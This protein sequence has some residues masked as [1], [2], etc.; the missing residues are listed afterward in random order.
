MAFSY[1]IKLVERFS[2]LGRLRMGNMICEVYIQSNGIRLFTQNVT[3]QTNYYEKFKLFDK[4]YTHT[5]SQFYITMI[6][7]FTCLM[8][9][10][11]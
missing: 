7:K 4:G 10:S 5:Y 6:N 3:H 11:D 8:I 1:K 9:Q 2:A